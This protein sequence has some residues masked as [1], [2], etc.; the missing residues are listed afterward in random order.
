MELAQSAS[1]LSY[2]KVSF[3]WSINII[4][5]FIKYLSNNIPRSLQYTRRP[6]GCALSL[7]TLAI[8]YAY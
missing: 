7:R 2:S 1:P 3:M 4:K 5:E 6:L 8:I